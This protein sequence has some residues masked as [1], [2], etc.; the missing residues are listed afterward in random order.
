MT[1]E[2]EET[3]AGTAGEMEEEMR[4]RHKSEVRVSAT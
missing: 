3:E 2:E 1:K 4:K